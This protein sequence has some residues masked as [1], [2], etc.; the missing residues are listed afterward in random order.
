[1][2]RALL[3]QNAK[4]SLS[5]H[6]AEAILVFVVSNAIIGT[7]NFILGFVLGLSSV[8]FD[9]NEDI[10]NL[11]SNG[12]SG[13]ISIIING[14]LALGMT[15]FYLKLSRKQEVNFNEL[16]SKTKMFGLYVVTTLLIGLF[17]AL[18]FILLIIPG[19]IVSIGLSQTYYIL[20]DNPEIDPMDAIKKSWNL[21][22][23]HKMEYFV[24][25]L[26]FIGWL[27]LGIFTCGILYFWLTPY[28]YVTYANY[29]N[30]LKDENN[31]NVI[32]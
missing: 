25:Q 3:K 18:G 10:V 27:I 1:M 8:M 28:M 6:Y 14:L 26:S 23:G 31:Y 21:M 4:D 11:I 5:G 13:I 30:Y 29:Y 32:Q 15:S 7:A 16:F 9:L 2:N 12:T 19:I 22:K 20:L 17:T 24:L